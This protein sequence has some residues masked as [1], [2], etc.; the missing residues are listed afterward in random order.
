MSALRNFHYRFPRFTAGSR[1]D[2][3]S[4]ETVHLGTCSEISE[5][6]LRCTFS[7]PVLPGS[8]GLMTLYRND[9]SFSAH[10]SILGNEE[11]E[12]IAVFNFRSAK[13]QVAVR[14]FIKA[15]AF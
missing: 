7:I 1:V 5:S 8:Q 3:I 15:L 10:A 12:V 11:D 2:F 4:G 6:G 14:E 13:E 9:T